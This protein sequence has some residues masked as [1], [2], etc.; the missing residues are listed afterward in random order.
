MNLTPAEQQRILVFQTAELARRSR[1]RG[2][3]LNAPEAISLIVDA[4]HWAARE[5][6]SYPEVVDAGRTSV[7]PDEVLDGVADLVAEV[8]AEVLLDEGSRLILL[9]TPLLAEPT[10]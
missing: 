7:R 5:G 10:E 1:E 3:L 6:R 9:R 4:M 8:R 2:L